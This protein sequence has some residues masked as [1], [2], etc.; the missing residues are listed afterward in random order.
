MSEELQLGIGGPLHRLRTVTPLGLRGLA[1]AVVLFA[2][3]DL[4]TLGLSSV[5]PVLPL[6]LLQV[7]AERLLKGLLHLVTGG[8]PG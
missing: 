7:P 5:L 2:P 8:V 4:I 3:R 6:V 1:L